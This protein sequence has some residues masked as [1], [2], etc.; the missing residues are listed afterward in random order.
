MLFHY[1]FY[2]KGTIQRLVQCAYRTSRLW[3]TFICLPGTLRQ[4]YSPEDGQNQCLESVFGQGFD[5]A[6]LRGLAFQIAS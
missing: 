6:T 3:D 5:F 2:F 1:F 4:E